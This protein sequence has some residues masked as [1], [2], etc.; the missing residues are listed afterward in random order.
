[1]K[2]SKSK[3]FDSLTA[4]KLQRIIKNVRNASRITN[5]PGDSDVEGCHIKFSNDDSS[6]LNASR[7]K[8]SHRKLTVVE[9]DK[10]MKNLA[11]VQRPSDVPGLLA[12]SSAS[13]GDKQQVEQEAVELSVSEDQYAGSEISFTSYH[14]SK[15]SH[16]GLECSADVEDNLAFSRESLLSFKDNVDDQS[17]R[18]N[19]QLN[20]SPVPAESTATPM[21]LFAF[22]PIQQ[23]AS[24]EYESYGET[25]R[26][27]VDRPIMQVKVRPLPASH[28]IRTKCLRVQPSDDELPLIDFRQIERN[29]KATWKHR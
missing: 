16:S 8:I 4:E 13:D 22:R 2:S 12:T 3:T 1:M 11:T 10:L 7:L 27:A 21:T 25:S 14:P 28:S 9:I 18:S 20:S 29:T 15:G 23:T 19:V 17:D 26:S 5:T 6:T 24:E